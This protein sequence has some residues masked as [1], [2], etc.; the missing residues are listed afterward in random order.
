VSEDSLYNIIL[1]SNSEFSK[2]FKQDVSKLL[3][4]LRNQGVIAIQNDEFQRNH[5]ITCL[6]DRI[7]YDKFFKL[8][9]EAKNIILTLYINE[10]V[11]YAFITNLSDP[12]HGDEIE[13][14][15]C[16]IQNIKFNI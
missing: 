16:F 9:V 5:D 7:D 2:A 14:N 15:Q 12:K 13:L 11:T 8:F 3:V 10:H 6:K 1:W 4:N